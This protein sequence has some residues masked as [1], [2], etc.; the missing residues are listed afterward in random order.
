MKN[1]VKQFE[2]VLDNNNVLTQDQLEDCLVYFK[3]KDIKLEV[4]LA[5]YIR[6]KV[7]DYTGKESL[8]S[9]MIALDYLDAI[10]ER[11]DIDKELLSK[12][13]KAISQ[14]IDT[15][16]MDEKKKFVNP[17]Q[18]IKNLE[19]VQ[20]RMDDIYYKALEEL[21]LYDLLTIAIDRNDYGVIESAFINYPSIVNEKNAVGRTVYS[22]VVEQ[23]LNSISRL[24]ENDYI[25]YASIIDLIRDSE[26]FRPSKDEIDYIKKEIADFENRIPLIHG[27]KNRKET[28]KLF[29]NLK[30]RVRSSKEVSETFES[31]CQKHFIVP[32][33]P[34]GIETND[35][36]YLPGDDYTRTTNDEYTVTIDKKVGMGPLD[37]AMSCVRL[38][39][40]N[41]LLQIHT[42]DP[43]GYYDFD[44][45]IIQEALRRKS[46]IMFPHRYN[47]GSE[48]YHSYEILPESFSMGVASLDAKK[49]RF[50][51]TYT[52]E[53][54]R[55][56]KEYE[57]LDMKKTITE[58]STN[59][60]NVN[61]ARILSGELYDEEL[62]EALYNIS[63]ALIMI[64]HIRNFSNTLD[65]INPSNP[66]F[67]AELERI[68][69]NLVNYSNGVKLSKLGA[70][71]P[72]RV[73]EKSKD[74]DS[75]TSRLLSELEEEYGTGQSNMFNT[76]HLATSG[77]HEEMGGPYVYATSPLREAESIMVNRCQDLYLY[78]STP[79]EKEEYNKEVFR[80]IKEY[81]QKRIN[82]DRFKS[83]VKKL[84]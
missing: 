19:E 34:K 57:D 52:Y 77:I 8:N 76:A 26:S 66:A 71:G 53:I 72:Y 43:L 6:D 48:I 21:S 51:R 70:P 29:D 11:I 9:V 27:K 73:F 40:G 37:D 13:A 44:S 2:T 35:K 75:S 82:N 4:L 3:K 74:Q 30:D 36:I 84:S 22:H 10:V 12:K 20:T 83:H 39:N 79:E 69:Q 42:T 63:N 38:P 14:R 62:T 47:Y 1:P 81:S 60:T 16:V 41:Y 33:C 50:S 17:E 64:N 45:D 28:R 7:V 59:T 68:A 23:A 65:N 5:D 32:A 15:K 31:L 78:D 67:S 46:V 25:Y 55:D 18:A 56:G 49:N 24:D 54:S 61:S 58:V 80:F